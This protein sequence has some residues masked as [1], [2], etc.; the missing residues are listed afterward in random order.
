MGPTGRLETSARNNHY[1]L[2]NSP[3][4]AQLSATSLWG[5][6]Y[7]ETDLYERTC[8]SDRRHT[9]AGSCVRLNGWSIRLRVSCRHAAVWNSRLNTASAAKHDST[10]SECL[11]VT[12]VKHQLDATLCTGFISAES[13]YM[14]WWVCVTTAWRV[15]MLRIVERPPIWR[16]TTLTNQNAI[17]EEIK[18]RLRSGNAWC[19]SVQNICLPGCYPK[20]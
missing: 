15:L 16:G 12:Q 6:V 17:L 11:N 5:E 20:I 14:C 3:I 2:H 13:L 9:V 18:S 4:T 19:H 7:V 1:S 10:P 8:S